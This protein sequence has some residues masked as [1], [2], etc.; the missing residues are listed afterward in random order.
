MIM[1]YELILSI[2]IAFEALEASKNSVEIYHTIFIIL[3]VYVSSSISYLNFSLR[4]M[5]IKGVEHH[6]PVYV[7]VLEGLL[8]FNTCKEKFEG[9]WYQ[10]FQKVQGYDDEITLHFA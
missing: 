2:I 10:F 4:Q 1:K 6:E 7:S 3:P 5:G 9:T 8:E